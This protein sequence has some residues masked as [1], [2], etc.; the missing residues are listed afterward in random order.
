MIAKLH[1][2]GRSFRGVVAYCLGEVR[3]GEDE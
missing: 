2:G 3:L 1:G